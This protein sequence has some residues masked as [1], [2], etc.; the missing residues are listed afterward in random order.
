MSYFF[1]RK[2]N[3]AFVAMYNECSKLRKAPQK[4]LY[5]QNDDGF[6]VHTNTA[7]H[8]YACITTWSMAAAV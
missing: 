8:A 7:C 3:T 2:E 5:V 6:G 1:L 4:Y